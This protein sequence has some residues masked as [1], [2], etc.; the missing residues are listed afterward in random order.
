MLWGYSV[1]CLGDA[2]W[3]TPKNCAI[4]FD[5]HQNTYSPTAFGLAVSNIE[6]V[7]IKDGF[8]N[9]FE[10]VDTLKNFYILHKYFLYNILIKC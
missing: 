7:M 5:V 2:H 4:F 1:W 6:H 8:M 3:D 9:F 10:I